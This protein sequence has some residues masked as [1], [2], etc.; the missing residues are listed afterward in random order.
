MLSSSLYSAVL[1]TSLHKLRLVLPVMLLSFGSQ[2]GAAVVPL[3]DYPTNWATSISSNPLINI[4]SIADKDRLQISR[5]PS[6]SGSGAVFYTGGAST[7]TEENQFSDFS[8]SVVLRGL[9]GSYHRGVI[10]RSGDKNYAAENAYFLAITAGDSPSLNLYWSAGHVFAPS[11]TPLV[12]D[13]ISSLASDRDYQLR[14]SAIGTVLSASLW[15]ANENGD[16]IN[17]LAEVK[18]EEATQASTGYFGLRGGRYGGNAVTYFS[19]LEITAIPE[20]QSVAF[21]ILGGALL[22]RK[23]R[24]MWA[25]KN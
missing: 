5:T 18:Y 2:L 6:N 15:G 17:L 24:Q 4:S 11:I 19:D 8:G 1:K 25:T 9:A 23:G 3:D 10:L 14:F 7:A 22:A 16:F 12:S 13:D 21:I 20:P